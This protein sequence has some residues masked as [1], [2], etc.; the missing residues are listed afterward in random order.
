MRTSLLKS[1]ILLFMGITLFI[2]SANAVNYYVDANNG[3]NANSGLQS[4][5]AKQTIQ[6][7]ADLT[8]PG[9]TVFV[10]NGTYLPTV[11]S[12]QHILKITRSGTE[13]NYITYKAMKGHTPKIAL[14]ASITWQVWRAVLIDGSY[15]VFDGIEVQGNNASLSYDGAYQN[16]L[17]YQSGIKDWVNISKYGAGAIQIGINAQPHHIVVR[18]CKLHDSGGVGASNCDYITFENNI[19]YNNCWYGLFAGSGI[20]ILE[21]ISIDTVTSYKI[22]IRNNIVYNNKGYIPWVTTKGLSDG[23]GIILDINNGTGSIKTV[24]VGRYLVTNNICYN[25]GGGGI[26][27]YKANHIDIINNTTYN[28]GT[29][30]GYPEIDALF[31]TD[32]KIYNNIMYA[33][34]GG[35]VNGNDTG[36][37]D[38]NLYYNSTAGPFKQG[39]HDMIGNPQF[40]TLALD[41]TDNLKLKNNSP[42]INNGSNVTGQFSPSDILGVA[43]PVGFLPDMG[44]Y[45]YATV[46]P[47]AEINVKQGSTDIVDNTGIFNF[48]DVPSTAPKT[49]LFTIENLGDMALNMTGTPKVEV[50]GIGFSLETDAPATISAV[51]SVTFQVKLTPAN[52]GVCSGTVSIAN[53]DANENPYNFAIAGYGYDGT[54]TLQTITF[55]A[56]PIKALG[57]ADFNPG[58]TTTSGLN[59]TY[60]SSNTSVASITANGTIHLLAAGSSTI[61]ASQAGDANTNIAKPLTQLLTVTPVLPQAGLN[62]ITNPNFDTNTTGWG[63]A[64]KKSGTGTAES[65][66]KDGFASNVIKI[67]PTALGT[68]TS[69]DNI[70]YGTSVFVVKDKN[71]VVSFRASADVARNITI[72]CLMNSSPY[73][74]IFNKGSIPLTTTPYN[75][76]PYSFTSTLTGY[77][78][79]RFQLGSTLSTSMYFDDIIFAEDVPNPT[80]INEIKTGSKAQIKVYPNPAKDLLKVDF[81]AKTGERVAIGIYDFQ[82]HAVSLH[83]FI[84]TNEGENT[85][86]LNVNILKKSLYL[87]KIRGQSEF[88]TTSKIVIRK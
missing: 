24:Y 57:D 31:S 3:N 22:I 32:V 74:T 67:T 41:G 6:A 62:M 79:L 2:S 61:T 15:I 21:P 68:T 20:S 9:D 25:N 81:Q 10:M 23:N 86:E 84:A 45:E 1:S 7:A 65:V 88:S 52:I 39:S 64:N 75:F 47:R 4:N 19:V 54:K 33:R 50:T 14:S 12:D 8:N 73:S 17:D 34:N 59:V 53:E 76:G 78:A 87:L 80:T 56:L 55:N 30:V 11:T 83:N 38:Y 42:A 51:G 66:V 48:G 18:N 70:Q 77:A 63:F 82:G 49:V 85:V 43:R 69:I 44:A 35:N 40:I 13:G 28:N 36:T 58:A 16:Y 29:Q 46:I 5:L 37:Y 72:Y 26:H 71:Y 60:T 27:A